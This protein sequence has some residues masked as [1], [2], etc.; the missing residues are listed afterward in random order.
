MNPTSN[1]KVRLES[2]KRQKISVA[3]YFRVLGII[4]SS[5][6]YSF[7]YVVTSSVSCQNY[8]LGSFRQSQKERR[9]DICW[10][11]VIQS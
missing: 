4:F 9:K 10:R 3:T 11:Q 8:F 7:K 5:N 6:K 1:V 2:N